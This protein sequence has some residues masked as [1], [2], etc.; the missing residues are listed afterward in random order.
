ME[1]E[2][3]M[4][5]TEQL[6]QKC[7]VEG[8]GSHFSEDVREETLYH[9]LDSAGPATH[10]GVLRIFLQWMQ[11]EQ[12]ISVCSKQSDSDP[13]VKGGVGQEPA[14]ALGTAQSLKSNS[15]ARR[16]K[17]PGTQR[18]KRSSRTCD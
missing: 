12:R 15:G 10:A 2:S 16:G 3:H 18:Q 5:Q 7:G 9:S 17:R 13:S 14:G 11:N 8:P 6:V 1:P 4:G